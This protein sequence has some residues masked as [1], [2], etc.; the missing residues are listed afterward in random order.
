MLHHALISSFLAAA[1]LLQIAFAYVWPDVHIDQL[2]SYLY[3]QNGY[4]ITSP[5]LAVGGCDG[6]G[7][8]SF[9][10][11]FGAEW[12]RTA[13]HDMATHNVTAGTGGLDA[14]IFFELDRAENPGSAFP[15]TLNSLQGFQNTRASM[16]DL[17]AL[18]AVLSVGTCSS[19]NVLIPFRAG[20]VDATEAGP[21]GVPEPQHDLSTHEAIFANAGF[22]VTD[23]IAMVACGHSIG[24][25]HANDFPTIVSKARS[26][27][28]GND[29]TPFDN[30][31]T[32]FDNSIAVNFVNNVTQDALA[33]GVN[34]TTRS[35]YRVFTADGGNL[36]SK[37]AASSNDY[38]S[39]CTSILERM[40]N[41]VPSTVTLTDVIEPTPLKPSWLQTDIVGS[42]I[43]F[44]GS[45]RILD[46]DDEAPDQVIINIIPR[47]GSCSDATPCLSFETSDLGGLTIFGQYA[48]SPS[49]KL[50]P[51]KASFPAD[52]GI[53]SFT[54]DYVYANG[55]TVVNSNGGDG[56]PFLDDI[57][58]LPSRTCLGGAARDAI[59]ATVAVLNADRYDKVTFRGYIPTSA[60]VP[61][62]EPSNVTM[63]KGEALAG[64]NYTLHWFLG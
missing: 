60:A 22:N 42:N 38:F 31:T 48:T 43:S 51:I 16:S 12:L 54:V 4:V 59:Q 44:T 64:T 23:M 36:I 56:F 18:G 2:E 46:T 25:V 27:V 7:S 33:Y 24:G 11:I 63:T 5:V 57:I 21:S 61:V 29:L 39:S 45:L 47:S 55:S 49:F 50:Y 30:T 40:L 53:S 6:F 19:G 8:P 26:I 1:Y 10:R 20:R 35:D 15:E 13:Y 62:F 9:G 58:V 52:L 14:S 28:L 41:T 3:E 37:L 34:E 17:V 32:T